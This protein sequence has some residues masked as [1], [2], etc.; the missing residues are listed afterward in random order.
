LSK[1]LLY[2]TNT[3]LSAYIWDKGVLSPPK[4]FDNYASGW[5]NFAEYLE[6]YDELPTYLLTDLIEEDFQLENIPHVFGSAKKALIERKLNNLYRDTPYRSA[7]NQG[8]E[9]EGRRDDKMLFSALTNSQ[10]IKPWT[11]ALESKKI[12]VTGVYSVALLSNVVFKKLGLENDATLLVTHQ[13]SGLRQSFFKDGYLRF[14]RLSPET[15]WSPETIA[16]MIN[17]EM[18]K[19][20]QFLVST[21]L[22][23]RNENI[24][25]VVVSAKDILEHLQPL[26]QNIENLSYQF[27]HLY[28]AKRL[29]GL[30]RLIELNLCDPLF[31]SLLASQ[32]VSTHYA[33]SEQHR[34]LLLA[35]TKIALNFISVLAVSIGLFLTADA[36]VNAYNAM[37]LTKQAKIE[38]QI[39]LSKYQATISSMP[40]TVVNPKDMKVAAE[41]QKMLILNGPIP[42]IRLQTISQAMANLPQIKIHEINWKASEPVVAGAEVSLDAPAPEILENAPISA[43]LLGL[44]KKPDEIIELEAEIVPFK[45]DYRTAIDVVNEFIRELKK[46]THLQVE[47]VKPPIDIRTSVVLESQSGNDENLIKPKFHLK[48]VWRP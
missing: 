10:L 23:N 48:L 16:E 37:Q 34:L 14:S 38:T 13:S 42:N 26:A 21:R 12:N 36:G 43:S 33:T 7:R 2:L 29:L 6:K 25:M 19:T 17:A 31:L 4:I 46:D 28:E 22:I 35:Q 5:T 41:L 15:A 39:A 45:N 11:D 24:T 47:L 44:G 8:R 9:K 27:I 1:H 3:Q 32:R 30:D 18:A 20:R 40:V